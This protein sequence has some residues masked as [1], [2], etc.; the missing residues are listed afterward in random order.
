MAHTT[1]HHNKYDQL[2]TVD[3]VVRKVV[4][5]IVFLLGLYGLVRYAFFGTTGDGTPGYQVEQPL[6]PPQ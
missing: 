2:S 5:P 4:L 6:A 1:H 3:R